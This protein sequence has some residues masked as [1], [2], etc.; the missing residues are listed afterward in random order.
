MRRTVA[1]V[2][3]FGTV[4]GYTGEMKGVLL[5]RAPEARIVDV[6]H[7]IAAGDVAAGA[8]A[9]QRVWRRFP[10]DT[11]HLVVVDPGVGSDRRPVAVRAEGRWF[12]GPDNG[13]LTHVLRR[14]RAREARRL[15]PEAVGLEPLSDTFHGR[16]LF[17][18]A[19]AHL[20]AGRP[21]EDLGGRAEVAS[22]VT[23]EVA[24]PRRVGSREGPAEIHGE[25]LHVDRFGNLVTNV[26]SGWLPERPTVELGACRLGSP[27]RSFASVEPGEP[28]LIRGSGGTLEICV[29]GGSAAEVLG[30]G[31]GASLRVRD[32]GEG[33][34]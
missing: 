20:A 16:D 21:S 4:D 26:P 19:A 7:E 31:R 12:V 15:D 34:A 23:L 14:W 8:W 6:T 32:G 25:V 24:A 33:D 3:D 29:R 2:T 5:S 9:L 28:V 22:L 1:L 30:A 27:G 11:V 18:P 10:E 17:A 13:L